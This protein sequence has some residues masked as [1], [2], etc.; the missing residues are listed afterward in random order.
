MERKEQ[1]AEEEGRRK[2]EMQRQKYFAEQKARLQL[3]R[4][5]REQRE[6]EDRQRAK[7]EAT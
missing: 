4:V 3:Q 1:E 5:D 7:E 2:K 6:I